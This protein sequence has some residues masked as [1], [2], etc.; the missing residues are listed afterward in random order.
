MSIAATPF[1]ITIDDFKHYINYNNNFNK[2]GLY[3]KTIS[4]AI[5]AKCREII[6]LYK[7][8][9]DNT[10]RIAKIIPK[11]TKGF[12]N[13]IDRNLQN[14]CTSN[15]DKNSPDFKE[16]LKNLETCRENR[17]KSQDECREFNTNISFEKTVKE[18][19]DESEMNKI[20]TRIVDL[21]NLKIHIDKDKKGRVNE[22][23]NA[24]L[25]SPIR[26]YRGYSY[27]DFYV[28]HDDQV[29]KEIAR[30]KELYNSPAYRDSIME[31]F[32]NHV[33]MLEIYNKNLTLCQNERANFY[34]AENKKFAEAET[35]LTAKLTENQ[36]YM[37]WVQDTFRYYISPSTHK[38]TENRKTIVEIFGNML[39]NDNYDIDSDSSSSSSDTNRSYLIQEMVPDFI[40]MS[41][42]AR[43]FFVKLFLSNPRVPIDDIVDEF[44][45]KYIPVS[46]QQRIQE[47][48]DNI[49]VSNTW[50]STNVENAWN[51]LFSNKDFALIGGMLKASSGLTREKVINALESVGLKDRINPSYS[52]DKLYTNILAPAWAEARKEKI[53]RT[54]KRYY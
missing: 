15:I 5:V 13:E 50:P 21:I 14:Y 20:L 41:L 39:A 24:P 46:Y 12:T 11:G 32:N 42:D 4:P 8:A 34:E 9:C 18:F 17:G 23:F 28:T 49:P 37:N 38:T 45:H 25:I 44:K 19:L 33:H 2:L 35:E 22:I 3:P 16:F 27:I 29:K 26:Y 7:T 40:N 52:K 10:L 6:K 54:S 36:T 31:S 53:R 51:N 30:I 1:Y 47:P 48:I 43:K